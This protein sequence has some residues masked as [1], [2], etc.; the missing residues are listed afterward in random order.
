LRKSKRASHTRS[1]PKIAMLDIGTGA[2]GI[3]PL[4]ACQIYGWHC[5]AID[6]N[7]WSL[8][9]VTSITAN[10]PM[11]KGRFEPRWQQDKNYISDSTIQPE[12][13]FDVSVCNPTFLISQQEALKTSQ[14][15]LTNLAHNMGEQMSASTE[16]NFGGLEAGLWC[17]GDEKLFV[18][19]L[20]KESQEFSNQRRW[21]TSLLSKIHNVKPAKN[22]LISK[23]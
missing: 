3:Y 22:S 21:F 13:Y 10:N 6:I 7:P 8:E 14:G 12:E 23:V 11:L 20:I 17:K 5:V 2:N 19:K 16:L 9:N 15:Q 18:K 1:Q 4:L